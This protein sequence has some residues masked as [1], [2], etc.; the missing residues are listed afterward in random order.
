MAIRDAYDVESLEDGVVLCALVEELFSCRP[1][2]YEKVGAGFYAQ[3]YA[4]EIDR[5]PHRFIIT[6]RSA[7]QNMH[8]SW[9]NSSAGASERRKGSR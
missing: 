6:K 1:Q 3:V 7:L 5:A 8:V 9:T 4:I 2:R